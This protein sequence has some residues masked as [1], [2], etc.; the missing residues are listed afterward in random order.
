[1]WTNSCI[2]PSPPPPDP[3]PPPPP[4]PSPPPNPPPPSP[5]P[6]SPP[7]SPPPP[8]TGYIAI[9][10]CGTGG[11]GSTL[12][13]QSGYKRDGGNEWCAD[14][15]ERFSVQCCWTRASTAPCQA[16]S[17]RAGSLGLLG[18]VRRPAG[19]FARCPTPTGW[20]PSRRS[21][22]RRR[23]R[24]A[25]SCAPW[26]RRTTR[27]W[28]RRVAQHD[29]GRTRTTRQKEVWAHAAQGLRHHGFARGPPR[30]ATRSPRRPRRRCRRA[31]GNWRRAPSSSPCEC[32]RP[33]TA[34]PTS[35]PVNH[36]CHRVIGFH[37][38]TFPTGAKCMSSYELSNLPGRGR[39]QPG[40]E[41]GGR[42]QFP[43][44]SPECMAPPP[45]EPPSPPPPTPPPLAAAS[46]PVASAANASAALAAA[47]AAAAARHPLELATCTDS[48]WEATQIGLNACTTA[49]TESAARLPRAR[50]SSRTTHPKRLA[51]SWRTSRPASSR[52]RKTESAY[53]TSN[54]RTLLMERVSSSTC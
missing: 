50:R 49:C 21:R 32:C 34:D 8:H 46:R 13:F 30:C 51:A 14:P 12:K 20:T 31:K 37:S 2:A 17:P 39:H 22:T 29:R 38:Q 27:R 19:Q 40:V 28:P 23:R 18:E 47:A 35:R 41:D 42:Q 43:L 33:W 1:M 15:Y 53:A 36:P 6:P 4:P 45:S 16:R 52:L 54:R 5:P 10:A 3:P 44:T 9:D 25:T 24:T 26:R 48:Q 11:L 7:S